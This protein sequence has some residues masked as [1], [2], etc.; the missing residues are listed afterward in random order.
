MSILTVRNLDISAGRTP[1]VNNVSLEINK[2][3]IFA[4]VGESG[5]GK[6]LTALSVM[7]LLPESL[8]VKGE[9]KILDKSIDHRHATQVRGKQIGM[10][11]QEPMTSLNPLHCI[12]KQIAEAISIHQNLDKKETEHKVAE[13]L[14]AVGLGNFK[15]RLDA[16][17]HQLSGGERQRVMIAM[18]IANNPALLIADEPTTALDVTIQAQ[19]LALLKSLQVQFGMSVLLITHDLTI[20]RKIAD[21]VAMMSQGKIVETNKTAEIFAYPKHEYTKR[22]LAAEPK[23]A[24]EPIHDNRD[25][26]VQCNHLS[27]GFEERQ[28]LFSWNSLY[29]NV[30]SDITLS[31]PAGTTLG[32]VGESG[33]GKTT[34]AL[35]LLRLIKSKGEIYFS[36][37]RIDTVPGSAL[38]NKRRHMQMVF[39]DPFSSLNPRLSVGDIV[40]EG[41]DVHE[42]KLSVEEREK[43]VDAILQEVGLSPE[44]KNRYPHEFS[45][46]QRQRISIARA[47]ILNP[48]LII[49]DEPTSA[50]DISVQAQ[51]LALLRSLQDKYKISY[52]FISHDLR[53]IRAMSHNIMVLQKGKIVESG[54]AKEIF[55]NP[56][57]DYTRTL[58]AAAL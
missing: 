17:P 38:R 52:I 43:K 21:R 2:G 32:V 58:L 8:A 35:A 49:L 16:Y 23:T 26:V 4:L 42:T 22:L 33:S 56:K 10:I 24:P 36:N 15:N 12:G 46:G 29:K 28:G 50:L 5:S 47:L 57:Q 55:A 7:G 11:F 1:L 45:G 3:E 40:R 20:V 9:W 14:D 39:Q 53:T 18:A 6:T 27:V 19:I 51:I 30:L 54:S 41:L 44:M 25:S 34:L 31:V 48:N 13:L 37:E